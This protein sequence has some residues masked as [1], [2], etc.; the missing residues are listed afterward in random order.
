MDFSED[1]ERKNHVVM[2]FG[3]KGSGKTNFI[4]HYIYTHPEERYIIYDHQYEHRI[5]KYSV[6]IHNLQELRHIDLNRGLTRKN[7]IIMRGKLGLSSTKAFDTFW[8]FAASCHGWTI[9]FDEIDKCCSA[10]Y[11]PAGLYDI[12]QFGRHTR[13]SLLCGARRPA[14]VHHDITSQ[15][16]LIITHRISEPRDLKYIADYCGQEV[17]EMAPKLELGEF[18]RYPQPEDTMG[19]ERIELNVAESEDGSVDRSHSST[20]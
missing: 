20:Y 18:V 4:K 10:H 7:K 14:N 5:D 16:N 8:L 12:V 2:V 15:A 6:L 1:I 3:I 17:A 11:I 19:A 9:V 13:V